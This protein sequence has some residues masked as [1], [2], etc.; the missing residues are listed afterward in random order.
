M[1]K[2]YDKGWNP[3]FGC[4]GGFDGGTHCYAAE[5]MMEKGLS[6][7]LRDVY[8]SR[9]QINRRFGKDKQQLI[10]VCI[11]SNLF[12]ADA[13]ACLLDQVMQICN[14]NGER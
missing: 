8:V 3:V 12:Q 14:K 1:L 11:Q 5:Q 13:N 9:K 4:H 2:Y 7:E 10:C 6:D